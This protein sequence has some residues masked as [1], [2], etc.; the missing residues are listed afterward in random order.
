VSH[1][2]GYGGS[3][4]LVTGD[5]VPLDLRPAGFA[6]RAVAFGIDFLVQFAALVASFLTLAL[7]TKGNLD[8]ALPV[9]IGLTLTVLTVVG[10]PVAFETLSRGRSLGKLALGL[11]VVSADGTP[12]RFRQSLARALSAIVEFWLSSGVVGL[13]SSLVNR[14]GRRIGDFLAGT[15]VIQE[16]TGHRITPVIDMPPPMADWA[17]T[18]EL[19]RLPADLA[20][21]AYQ[22]LTRYLAFDHQTR[23]EL[24]IQLATAVSQYVSPP[25]PPQ[26]SPP[27]YL[28][29]VLAERR[30][31]EAERFAQIHGP[32]AG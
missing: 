18:A 30:R 8:E 1:S 16:R 7:L 13:A 32:S 5:A 15:I 27:E 10:Y 3:T 21:V 9:A 28:A 22:Y 26:A 14:Q 20:A 17:R 19:S 31:R 24:G 4:S 6:S 12:V 11:R 2:A 25:P 29:A 23:Y